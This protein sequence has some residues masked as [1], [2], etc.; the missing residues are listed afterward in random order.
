MVR[1][2]GDPYDFENDVS[3]L[4]EADL[5]QSLSGTLQQAT[6]NRCWPLNQV[7]GSLSERGF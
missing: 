1:I 5:P 3:V 7:A 4:D 6:G 2:A